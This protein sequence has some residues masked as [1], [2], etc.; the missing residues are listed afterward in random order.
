MKTRVFY[1]SQTGN[2]KKIAASIASALGVEPESVGEA[3]GPIEA[4]LLFIGGAVYATHDHGIKPELARFIANLD[5]RKVGKAAIFCT[6]FEDRASGI[7]RGLLASKGIP[8]VEQHFFCKGKFFLFNLGHPGT[9]DLEAAHAFALR[10][11]GKG[12]AGK[13][14]KGRA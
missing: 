8:I 3:G 1:A 6:G 2:T 14:R 10:V 13:T 7:L 12:E 4:D 11:G 5:P 9:A